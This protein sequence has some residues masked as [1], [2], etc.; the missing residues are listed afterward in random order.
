MKKITTPLFASLLM[1]LSSLSFAASKPNLLAEL[2]A[3]TNTPEAQYLYS[4]S[5]M[6]DD[7]VSLM[8]LTELQKQTVLQSK[9]LAATEKT[10]E[11]LASLME[12]GEP[13]PT[14]KR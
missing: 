13:Y 1:V 9:Q 8:L 14:L 11:L 10:N 6:G 4:L 5:D 2:Q 12:G 7:T 3:T